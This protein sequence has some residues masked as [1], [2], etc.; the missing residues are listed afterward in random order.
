MATKDVASRHAA[1]D[2]FLKVM[3]EGRNPGFDPEFSDPLTQFLERHPDLA[4]RVKLSLINLLDADD[5]AF[6]RRKSER[7]TYTENDSEHFAAALDLVSCLNDERAIPALIGAMTAGGGSCNGLLRYGQ[8][9]LVPLRREF[10]NPDPLVHARAVGVAITILQMSND[11]ASH[12]QV[13]EIIRSALTDKE[14]LVRSDALYKV[15][16]LAD[17]QKFVPELQEMAQHDPFK[18]PGDTGYPLRARASLLLEKITS[19]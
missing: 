6:V 17:R 5:E 2:D 16:D 9:P 12:A 14:F 11:A 15:E 8:K 13:L 18:V 19:H 4:D 1:L 3:A 7:G 10:G